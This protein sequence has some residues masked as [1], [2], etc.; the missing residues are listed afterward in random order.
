MGSE[1]HQHIYEKFVEAKS[2]EYDGVAVGS[3]G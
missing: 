1:N 2:Q 3:S